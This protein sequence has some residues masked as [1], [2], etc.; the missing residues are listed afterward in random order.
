MTIDTSRTWAEISLENIKDNVRAIRATLPE[1]TKFMGVVK[2]D[3]YGHGAAHVAEAIAEAGGD[4]LAV[5]CFAEAAMLRE[6]GIKLPILILGITPPGYAE[7]LR[8]LD[9]TQTVPS[10]VYAKAL[11]EALEGNLKCHL[12]LD[13]GMSRTGFSWREE[14][15]VNI[16][17][18]MKLPKLNFEGVFTHFAVSDEP[19][20][21][22]TITQFNR[23]MSTIKSVEESCGHVFEIKHC[24]NSGAVINFREYALDMVRPGIMTYGMYPAAERG[25]IELKSAMSLK[26]RVYAINELLPGDTVGYGR[27]YTVEKPMRVA[28]IPVGYADG[29]SRS[30][31]GKLDVLIRGKRCPQIGR[32]C[33]D[34]F[35]VDIT[36]LSECELEDV[37][38]I[39][40]RDG[41]EE[42]TAD[43]LAAKQ[44][45]IN[46][47]ITCD[48]APRVTRIYT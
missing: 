2:A 25:G 30:L 34:M 16:I 39:I 29:I 13:S 46:Y 48:V 4:Y 3:A 18:T 45:S 35:M 36:E 24:A 43:E 28:T 33:M 11:S 9:I 15:L 23:F 47:E 6:A 42:I 17:E 44:G 40:G 12:K 31:S 5:A 32:I 14:S 26:S 7:E 21:D 19:E 20:K 8:K 27:A 10:L 37:V 38:T 22:F 1:G 41:W